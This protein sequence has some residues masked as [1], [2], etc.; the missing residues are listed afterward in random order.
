MKINKRLIEELVIK[1]TLST[2]IS[3]EN[4]FNEAY[5]GFK[6][7][8][9]NLKYNSEDMSLIEKSERIEYLLKKIRN[10]ATSLLGFGDEQRSSFR[11][12][13]YSLRKDVESLKEEIEQKVNDDKQLKR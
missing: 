2:T 4:K 10:M 13:I 12:T 5:D 9:L 3:N 6:E 8:F 11:D 1:Y 7:E